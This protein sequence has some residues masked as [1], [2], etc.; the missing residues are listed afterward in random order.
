MPVEPQ[1]NEGVEKQIAR[2]SFYLKIQ[3]PRSLQQ[4]RIKTVIIK[5]SR[6]FIPPCS[7]LG[8]EIL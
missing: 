8:A 5:V 7:Q 4:H 1:L 3:Q 2:T 6:A